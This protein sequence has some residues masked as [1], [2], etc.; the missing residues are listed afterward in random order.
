MHG[1]YFRNE[2][3]KGVKENHHDNK[4]IIAKLK[5]EI[6]LYNNIATADSIRKMENITEYGGY[7]NIINKLVI[8]HTRAK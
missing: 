3:K 4:T 6:Q 8:I 2:R 1:H 7:K 5:L